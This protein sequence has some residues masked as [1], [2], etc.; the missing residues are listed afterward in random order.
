MIFRADAA[1]QMFF[2]FLQCI[3]NMHCSSD[4]AEKPFV[5]KFN[6]EIRPSWVF[7]KIWPWW[8]FRKIWPL[9]ESYSLCCVDVK[10]VLKMICASISSRITQDCSLKTRPAFL[11]PSSRCQSSYGYVLALCSFISTYFLLP[12]KLKSSKIIS[13]INCVCKCMSIVC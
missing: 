1:H 10:S 8:V 13:S 9:P 6:L 4:I 7:R 11:S 2:S 3:Q 5:P 12:Q